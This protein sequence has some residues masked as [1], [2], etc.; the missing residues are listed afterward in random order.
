MKW[1]DEGIVIYKKALQEKGSLIGLLTLER[2]RCHGWMRG[3]NLP[4]LGDHVQAVWSARTEDQLGNWK[5]EHIGR[6]TTLQQPE[7][8]MAISSMCQL[9]QML[10]E[11]HTYAGVFHA[12]L[13]VVE[14]NDNWRAAYIMFEL[15]FLK[16]MG[17]GL[18][19]EA[20]A[21]T[22]ETENLAYVSPKTGCAVTKEVGGPYHSQLLLLPDF[23]THVVWPPLTP[24]MYEQALELTGYFISKHVCYDRLP[25]LRQMLAA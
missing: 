24:D 1:Q 18:S 11:R 3:Q 22:K 9:C 8:L 25:H 4:Q 6:P 12:A 19:L 16:E 7:R 13:D 14:S 10:P 20:C 23:L 2:G 5:L 15:V 17:F 21:V